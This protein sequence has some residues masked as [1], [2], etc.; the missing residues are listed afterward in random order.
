MT[1]LGAAIKT[2]WD[3]AS[4]LSSCSVWLG[5]APPN[6]AYPY[7]VFKEQPNATFKRYMDGST[8]GEYYVEFEI[9]H[10][11]E[12]TLKTLQEALHTAFD[13]ARPTMSSPTRCQ[14]FLRQG[15]YIKS[16]EVDASAG[17]VTVYV[18]VS[19]YKVFVEYP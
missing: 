17:S 8:E 12:A 2:V 7:C 11:N 19:K 13:N 10:T 15:D 5:I 4:S 18:A 6:T 1:K 9:R 16:D 3:G 14:G